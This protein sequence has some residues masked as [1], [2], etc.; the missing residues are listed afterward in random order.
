MGGN[1][2]L[3]EAYAPVAAGS[4]GV[5]EHLQAICLQALLKMVG[6]KA[7]LEGPAAEANPVEPG[8]AT[9]QCRRARQDVHKTQVESMAKNTKGDTFGKVVGKR[10]EHRAGVND[11]TIA[12]FLDREGVSAVLHR[13]FD[14]RFQFNGR[15]RFIV[16]VLAHSGQGGDGV[17]QPAGA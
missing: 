17:K 3:P 15:L 8:S 9:N 5:S 6:E 11:P 1:Y 16:H 13:L 4:F 10:Q 2:G 12:I 14:D 7:I